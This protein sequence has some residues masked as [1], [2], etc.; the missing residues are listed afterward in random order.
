MSDYWIYATSDLHATNKTVGSTRLHI[1][2]PVFHKIAGFIELDS[3]LRCIAIY[4]TGKRESLLYH[5]GRAKG[6]AI[7][8]VLGL[9]ALAS[10][11]VLR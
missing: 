1:Q 6:I 5:P 8:S 11:A 7:G 10:S 9:S 4:E 3:V 2:E